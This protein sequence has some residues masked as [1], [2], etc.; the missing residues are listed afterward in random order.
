MGN[1][2]SYQRG[3]VRLCG[4]KWYGSFRQAVLDPSTKERR[5]K[6]RSVVL[7]L[8]SELSK[9]AARELLE[10]VITRETGNIV[11][12]SEERSAPVTF[13]WFVRNRFFPLKE[14]VWRPETA[15][16]KRLL[17]ERNLIDA[18][19]STPME[20]IDRFTLQLHLNSLAKTRDFSTVL[21]MRAYLKSIFAEA[22]DMG[23]VTKDVARLLTV[24][25]QLRET[26]RTTLT[27]EQLGTAL[28][29]LPL[30]DR[31]LLETDMTTALRPGEL[32]ALRW[33]C[34]D[35]EQGTMR[36][37]E[38]LYRGEL[39]PW[40]K[41][42]AALTTVHIP[43]ELA[44]ALQEWRRQ[45]PN[46]APDAPIFP[47]TC[48][49]FMDSSNYRKRVLHRL[50]KDLKLPKLTFQVIRRTVATLAQTKGSLKDV[51][52]ILRHTRAATTLDVYVQQVPESV[53]A[54]LDAISAELRSKSLAVSAAANC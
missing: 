45:C 33:R 28:A 51:Q 8:R 36:L 54:T 17:I 46:S 14:G 25:T 39:R 24:P 47:D 32:F 38:T 18:F 13:G 10:Q 41:T 20:R 3:N 35:Y 37:S 19:D 40:G 50:A 7:G 22:C 23:F 27:W 42:R 1:K 9:S 53:Q 26:D 49:G 11:G 30:R 2:K 4:R 5:F 15:K 16:T 52:G 44:D 29:S 34:F 48:G 31:V 6:Q 43:R 12:G 21:Q